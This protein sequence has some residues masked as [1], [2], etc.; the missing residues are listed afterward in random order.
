M[1]VDP[2]QIERIFYRSTCSEMSQMLQLFM[3]NDQASALRIIKR[4]PWLQRHAKELAHKMVMEGALERLN[5]GQWAQA[6]GDN[7]TGLVI[8]LEGSVDVFTQGPKDRIVQFNQVGAGGCLGQTHEFGGGPR[9]VTAVCAEPT[10][11]LRVSDSV[12][13]RIAKTDPEIWR[14]VSALQNHNMR[15]TLRLMA[16]TLSLNPRERLAARLYW[17]H[18]GRFSQGALVISQQ[19]LGEL[20]GATRKTVN[21]YL[22]EFQKDGLVEIDYGRVKVLDALGLKRIFDT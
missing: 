1:F 8:V 14:A 6:E 11:V 22:S 20:I 9:M 5:T 4:L 18:I 19:A 10:L 16:E 15:H 2:A 17:L 3:K 7:V 13:L 21:G 12:L